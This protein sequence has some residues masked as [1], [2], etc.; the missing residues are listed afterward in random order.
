MNVNHI[1][2][3]W[4]LGSNNISNIDEEDH[5]LIIK[6]GTLGEYERNIL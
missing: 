3:L 4:G 2:Q 1:H 6:H 5:C